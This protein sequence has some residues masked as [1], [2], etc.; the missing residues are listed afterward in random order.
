MNWR[1][2]LTQGGYNILIGVVIG[3]LL[4]GMVFQLS[5]GGDRG[6]ADNA[7]GSGTETLL[8]GGQAP[9]ATPGANAPAA[10][11][12]GAGTARSTGG[13]ISAPTVGGTSLSSTNGTGGPAG[14][15]GTGGTG[16]TGGAGAAKLTASDVGVTPTTIKIGIGI[17]TIGQAANFAPIEG[18]DP[19][20]QREQWKVFI[21]RVNTD[22]GVLGRKLV[23]YYQEYD[24]T[25]VESAH[26]ACVTLT[27]TYH[28]FAVFGLD[29]TCVAVQNK[30]LCFC[31]GAIGADVYTK[32][33]FLAISKSPSLERVMSDWAR[34][35]HRLGKLRGRTLGM[36][37][38]QNYQPTAQRSII[39]TL[40]ALGY[41]IKYTAVVTGD[42]SQQPVQSAAAVGPMRSAGVDA[43]ILNTANFVSV[44]AFVNQADK[45]QWKP[46][47]FVNDP[48]TIGTFF[49][50]MPESWKGAL[51][52]TYGGWSTPGHPVP[53]EQGCLDY[54]NKKT[55]KSYTIKSA[56]V[57]TLV[58]ACTWMNVFP[59]A[60]RAVGPNLTRFGMSAA[61][62]RLGAFPLE[63]LGGT[64][65]PK[66]TD[67]NQIVRPLVWGPKGQNS[68]SCS[69]N[70]NGCFNDAG[71][72]LDPRR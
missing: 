60:G 4:S 59:M 1:K 49:G 62:Q 54:F 3:A 18:Q 5:R 36:L 40:K 46:Q 69:P 25:S 8:D 71:P 44:N 52:I 32:S 45:E 2:H 6:S 30:T 19:D 12:A 64:F 28:V 53:V 66:K 14:P 58:D 33:R 35:L 61:V 39:P 70:N 47:Y 9:G 68:S 42:I 22:G 11:N 24:I 43:V 65:G 31:S 38:D 50:G 10:G 41:K 55:G 29:P 37:L 13:A 57:H 16:G 67:Y 63:G 7:N 48:N 21:D 51:A 15:A 23:P 34:A 17:L 56:Q 20:D 72:A 27:Q 26:A